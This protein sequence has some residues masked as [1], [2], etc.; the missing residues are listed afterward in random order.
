M[1]A[2]VPAAPLQPTCVDALGPLLV[3][4]REVD[5]VRVRELL[6]FLLLHRTTTRAEAMAALWPDLDDRAGANNLRVTLSH[7]LNLIEPDRTEGEAAYTLR[8]GG[9]ELRLVIGSG[10]AVD[11]D[12]FDADLR[13]AQAAESDGSASVALAH[14]VAAT[15]RYRGTLLADL[16]DVTWADL[17]R[18]RCRSRFVAAAVRAAE[19]LAASNEPEQAELL[20]QRALQV[21]EWCERAY[22][23]LTSVAFARGDW[24]AGMRV[25]DRCQAMLR[26]LGVEPSEATRQLLRRARAPSGAGRA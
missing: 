23:A 9:S 6:G 12:A 8:A 1:L 11:V 2:A 3:G 22:G 21:D 17:E 7:L 20:A 10:V 16:P 15:D 19:L 18:E 26:E 25:L 4:G 14:L 5:R 13:A 24:S